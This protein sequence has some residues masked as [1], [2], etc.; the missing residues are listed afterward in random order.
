MSSKLCKSSNLGSDPCCGVTRKAP[1][2]LEPVSSSNMKLKSWH[3]SFGRLSTGLI[4]THQNQDIAS[5]GAQTQTPAPA[6]LQGRAPHIDKDTGAA[7]R[8][9]EGCEELPLYSEPDAAYGTGPPRLGLA[10]CRAAR[11]ALECNGTI[12]AH[13][14]LHLL[15]S[16]NTPTS[17]PRVAETTGMDKAQR[18]TRNVLR[19]KSFLTETR[20][21]ERRFP[22][23]IHGLRLMEHTASLCLSL[24]LSGTLSD[25]TAEG[26]E[27]WN[28]LP[29]FL[30]HNQA[31][32]KPLHLIQSLQL[33]HKVT[34]F[35]RRKKSSL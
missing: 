22:S 32:C 27:T 35:R 12:S 7:P 10:S 18:G 25:V 15:G 23:T 20:T 5:T 28:D 1:V 3:L 31:L 16:S 4:G 13:C 29:S 6:R 11:H 30:A 24:S 19:K 17:A 21:R 26:K 8:R 14:S 9:R 2:L 34:L 33:Y